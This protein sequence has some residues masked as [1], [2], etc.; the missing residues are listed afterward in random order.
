[1]VSSDGDQVV[2]D[3]ATIGMVTCAD[4]PALR[5]GVSANAAPTSS[6]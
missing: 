1:M 5:A 3:A 4:T 6:V 2:H